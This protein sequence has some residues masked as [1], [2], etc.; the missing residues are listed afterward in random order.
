[1]KSNDGNETSQIWANV[2]MCPRLERLVVNDTEKRQMHEHH[3][4]DP[5]DAL[6]A[7]VQAACAVSCSAELK[8]GEEIDGSIF[9]SW[10]PVRLHFKE[11]DFASFEVNVFTSKLFVCDRLNL[12]RTS[13][14]GQYGSPSHAVGSTAAW[15]PCLICAEK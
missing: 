6:R 7:K 4:S 14:S 10:L 13:A 9:S 1:M 8:I 5:S 12:E 2:E 11:L 15:L 3:Q